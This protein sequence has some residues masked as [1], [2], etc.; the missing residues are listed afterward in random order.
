[1]KKILIG[2]VAFSFL[3]LTT[4]MGTN[5]TT[6]SKEVKKVEV[7]VVKESKCCSSAAATG[8]NAKSEGKESCS[9]SCSKSTGSAKCDHTKCSSSCKDSKTKAEGQTSK[10]CCKKN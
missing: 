6:T 5:P 2:A 9:K 1:M 10:S 8:A 3:A 7:E 4:V